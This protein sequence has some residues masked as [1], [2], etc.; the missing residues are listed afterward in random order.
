[1]QRGVYESLTRDLSWETM[2]ERTYLAAQQVRIVRQPLSGLD[3]LAHTLGLRRNRTSD[4]A[5]S[6]DVAR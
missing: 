3:Q 2:R 6:R 5:G 4:R 1:M